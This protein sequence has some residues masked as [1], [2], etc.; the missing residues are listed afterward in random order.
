MSPEQEI[1]IEL[2]ED[3]RSVLYQGLAQW[4]GPAKG[5]EAMAVAMGFNGLSDL[6]SVGYRIAVEVR[7]E[8]A[9][10]ILDWHRA[11]LATEIM[12]ASEFIGAGLEWHGVTGWDDVTTLRLIRSVQLKVLHTTA[13][14]LRGD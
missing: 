8:R 6:Y 3:E 7:E 5:T 13:P 14:I 1:A 12:F 11:V 10:T 2:T 4:G 9:L